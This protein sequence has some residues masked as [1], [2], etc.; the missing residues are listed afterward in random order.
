MLKYPSSQRQK[1]HFNL[2]YGTFLSIFSKSLEVQGNIIWSA[3]WP[4]QDKLHCNTATKMRSTQAPITYVTYDMY[5]HIYPQF[6]SAFWLVWHIW[7]TQTPPCSN[8][9]HCQYKI[10]ALASVQIWDP[11]L[12][13]SVTQLESFRRFSTTEGHILNRLAKFGPNLSAVKKIGPDKRT[14]CLKN[15][16]FT[17][18]MNMS[19]RNSM[20]CVVSYTA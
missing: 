13:F 10:I 7:E 14:T 3:S 9:T 2:Q 11:V 12:Q 18:K 15:S 8:S 4:D 20:I 16:W 19:R 5:Y 6:Q 1:K 17:L